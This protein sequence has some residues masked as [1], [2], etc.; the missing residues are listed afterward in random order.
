LPEEQPERKKPAG[1]SLLART[2][3]FRTGAGAMGGTR[4]L[5]AKRRRRQDRQEERNA[6]RERE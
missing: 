2:A 6:Q 4:K 5:Q 1:R 3:H